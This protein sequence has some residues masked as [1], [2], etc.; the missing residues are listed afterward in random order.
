MVRFPDNGENPETLGIYILDDSDPRA[1]VVHVFGEAT[2][3]ETALFESAIVGAARIGRPVVI[4]FCECGYMDCGAVGVIVRAAKNLGDALRLVMP[5]RGQ[6]FRI[7]EITGLARA[8]HVFETL[9]EA[10]GPLAEIARRP[11]LRVV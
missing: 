9:D 6:G 4:D 10:V 2:F 7:L 5:R 1:S 8:L 11:H 3:S